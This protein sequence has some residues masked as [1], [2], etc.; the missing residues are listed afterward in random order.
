MTFF[1]NRIYDCQIEQQN[2]QWKIAKNAFGES[3]YLKQE[4][5]LR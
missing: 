1:S 4:P 5:N 3:A 2:Q